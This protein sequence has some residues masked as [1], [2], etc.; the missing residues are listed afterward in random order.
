M[1][2]AK[3]RLAQVLAEGPGAGGGDTS[4]PHYESVPVRF[5]LLGRA[6]GCGNEAPSHINFN[7]SARHTCWR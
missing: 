1:E 7:E 2:L 6:T 4:L 3:R 5:S